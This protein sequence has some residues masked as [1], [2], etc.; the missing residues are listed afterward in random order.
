MYTDNSY[1]NSKG[2][3]YLLDYKSDVNPHKASPIY[4]CNQY[5]FFAFFVF[6]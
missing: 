3:Q 4:F 2:L 5:F 1:Q 6:F